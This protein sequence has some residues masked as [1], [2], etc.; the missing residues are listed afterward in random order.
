MDELVAKYPAALYRLLETLDDEVAGLDEASMAAMPSAL[1][2]Y[3]G[4]EAGAEVV[5]S[6]QYP[7]ALNRLLEKLDDEVSGSVLEAKMP[8]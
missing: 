3:L 1:L 6:A 4:G 7:D 5:G 2:H 8:A